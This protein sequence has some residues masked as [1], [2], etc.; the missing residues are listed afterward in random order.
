MNQYKYHHLSY[1]S[2]HKNIL[3]K[4]EP[5]LYQNVWHSPTHRWFYCFSKPTRKL[6][7]VLEWLV[8]FTVGLFYPQKEFS[9]DAVKSTKSRL[10]YLPEVMKLISVLPLLA[11][12]NG[13]AI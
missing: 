13:Q 2:T 12:P 8:I 3:T 9:I 1:Q 4:T 6:D 5:Q 11:D 10:K 7:Q